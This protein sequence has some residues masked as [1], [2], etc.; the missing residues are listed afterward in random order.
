MIA[1]FCMVNE[2]HKSK[3]PIDLEG[4][5]SNVKVTGSR[6]RLAYNSVPYKYYSS[7]TH[8]R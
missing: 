4:C 8:A 7:P 3:L 5:G 1:K 6:L 2:H